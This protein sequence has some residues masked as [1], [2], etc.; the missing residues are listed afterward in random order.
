MINASYKITD[1]TIDHHDRDRF[2]WSFGL[3]ESGKL[4]TGDPRWTGAINVEA[5][6]AR[7][8]AEEISSEIDREIMKVI[9]GKC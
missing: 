1:Y 5:E 4:F 8:L 7:E 3:I 9:M 2:F 6:L